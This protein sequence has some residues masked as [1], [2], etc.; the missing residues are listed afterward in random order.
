MKHIFPGYYPSTA[1]SINLAVEE[2]LIVFDANVLLNLYRYPAETS[3]DLLAIM[4]CISNRIW[5]P[6][7]V[8]LE[9]HRNRLTVV[10]E[11]NRRFREARSVVEKAL[12]SLDGELGKLQLKKRHS[13]IDP[14]SLMEAVKTA[15]QSFYEQLKAQEET[16]Q[17]VSSA[18]KILDQLTKLF[19]NRV[20]NAPT[21]QDS[22]NSIEL[23]GKKRYDN[24]I[25][26]GYR[27]QSKDGESFIHAGLVYANKYGDLMLWMQMV[28]KCQ[29]EGIKQL[30]FVT[31]DDK[32]D[33]W[34][35]VDS[36]GEKRIGPRTELIEELS[37]STSVETFVMLSSD[38]FAQRFSELLNMDLGDKTVAVVQDV[39]STLSNR[40]QVECPSCG[41]QSFQTLGFH[42]GSSAV[43]F[44]EG[45]GSRYHVHRSGDVSVFTREWG[46]TA[47]V[48]TTYRVEAI[49][50][51]CNLNVPAHFKDG[52][53]QT[54]RYCMGCCTLLT[55]GDSGEVLGTE[56]SA[57]VAAFS[58]TID[59]SFTYL[60][61]P[62]CP[63][64]P[65]TRTIWGNGRVMRA[66]CRTCNC[67][68]ESNAAQVSTSPMHSS[69]G[70]RF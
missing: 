59:G 62:N 6:H 12:G 48:Q 34:F 25:P 3:K 50:P 51:E 41:V 8:A 22:L 40:E 36:E 14:T 69:G 9:Y 21:D 54:E 64:N 53:S 39:K 17:K 15:S 23:E 67:L 19:D 42:T 32:D 58:Q 4:D 11:Q 33:W 66:V 29:A 35:I 26:P 10:S 2:T 28:A 56:R 5:L 65:Q 46:G 47:P 24:K 20:G 27:D 57:S 52:A 44:C 61:C 1:A 37:K 38:R 49:C 31:D 55:I 60:G 68:L 18:D 63:G 7:Q 16:H 30:V 70:P 43:H 13:T 45:C